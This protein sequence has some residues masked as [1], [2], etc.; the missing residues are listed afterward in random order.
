MSSLRQLVKL[1]PRPTLT[2]RRRVLMCRPCPSLQQQSRQ[3]SL[4]YCRPTQKLI[5]ADNIISS[6][7]PEITVPDQAFHHLLFDRCEQFK[8]N[9][10]LVCC[11]C[12]YLLEEG[13]IILKQDFLE[14]RVNLLKVLYLASCLYVGVKLIGPHLGW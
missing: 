13:E 5:S 2:L 1:S 6:P 11:V 14:I 7:T 8:D 4:S 3:L 10:A 9:T 12:F